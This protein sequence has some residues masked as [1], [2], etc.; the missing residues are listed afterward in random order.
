MKLP[1][2]GTERSS[3]DWR[4]GLRGS[5]VRDFKGKLFTTQIIP[6]RILSVRWRHRFDQIT[7]MITVWKF[8]SNWQAYLKAHKK[9]EPEYLSPKRGAGETWTLKASELRHELSWRI[10]SGW[11][12]RTHRDHLCHVALRPCVF[13]RVLHLHQDDEVQVMPHVVL[14]LDVLL[15]GDCLVVKLVPLQA[16]KTQETL[17]NFSLNQ[18]FLA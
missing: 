8:S 7:R 4:S 5:E 18:N 10:R 16:C 14:W 17:G 2:L 13:C 12:S 3:D 11:A 1:D 9:S 15:E 6:G